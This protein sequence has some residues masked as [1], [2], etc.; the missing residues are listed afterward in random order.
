MKQ[1]EHRKQGNTDERE[2]QRRLSADEQR[3]L[4]HFE[5]QAEALAQQGYRRVELTVGIVK[6]NV[7]AVV[8]LIPLLI[9]GVGL[10]LLRNGLPSAALTPSHPLLVLTVLLLLIV[11]HELI[12]GLSWAIFAEHHFRDIAFGVI[13]QYLTPYCSCMTPLSRGQ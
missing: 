12:H 5:A 6:A 11:V 9:I 10:F 1:A 2:K 13:W 3:R 8:L 7:F 4:A